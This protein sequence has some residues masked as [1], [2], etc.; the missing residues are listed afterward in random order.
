MEIKSSF[1]GFHHYAIEVKDLAKSI[2]FYR[3]VLQF[4]MLER[5]DFDFT[6]AWFGIGNGQEI[7]LIENSAVEI[8]LTGSRSLH[9]A[10]EVDDLYAVKSYMIEK[11]I[12]IVKDIKK[13][14]DGVLQLFIK[15]PDGYFIEFTQL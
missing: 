5:P 8:T 9:F 10:F 12:F 13:R 3:D 2:S 14:P 4:P 15:D 6:G 11:D 1:K 7:H